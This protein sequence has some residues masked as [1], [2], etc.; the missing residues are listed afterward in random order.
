MYQFES[1]TSN[2]EDIFHSL[3]TSNFFSW[4]MIKQNIKMQ[5][6]FIINSVKNLSDD[7]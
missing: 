1:S 2:N 6:L 5:Q 3:S 4:F 7:N